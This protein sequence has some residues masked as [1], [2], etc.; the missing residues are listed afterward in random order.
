MGE[1]FAT[2]QKIPMELICR[3]FEVIG[4]KY[5]FES[6]EFSVSDRCEITEVSE[7]RVEQ[8]Q[9]NFEAFCDKQ[10]VLMQFG[11]GFMRDDMGLRP[12]AA[13][14][15]L[16]KRIRKFGEQF[17]MTNVLSHM[18]YFNVAIPCKE[19]EKE[20][21]EKVKQEMKSELAEEKIGR[22]TILRTNS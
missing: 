1:A 8:L 21:F 10:M 18:N 6:F 22:K 16:I 14:S 13:I 11:L 4:S 2:H 15:K 3:L 17:N 19:E 12:F 9:K 5:Y 7:E 20:L